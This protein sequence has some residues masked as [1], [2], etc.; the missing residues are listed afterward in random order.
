MSQ[1]IP[2]P[3]P[4]IEPFPGLV[5]EL[6]QDFSRY[7]GGKFIGRLTVRNVGTGA[8]QEGMLITST[9]GE[10]FIQVKGSVY[11]VPMDALFSLFAQAHEERESAL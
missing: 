9:D 3:A 5:C 2:V 11:S 6:V 4:T 7:H 8:D 1:P 10:W